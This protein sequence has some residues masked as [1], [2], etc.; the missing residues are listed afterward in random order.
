MAATAALSAGVLADAGAGAPGGPDPVVLTAALAV[1]VGQ[2]AHLVGELG[3]PG[4]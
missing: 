3:R 1:T 2:I 4:A